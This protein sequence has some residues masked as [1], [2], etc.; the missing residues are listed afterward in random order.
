MINEIKRGRPIGSSNLVTTALR[1]K[2]N[3]ILEN[4]LNTI[5]SD[6]K[7]LEPK[8]RL[9]IIER[10]LNY[11]LPKLANSTNEIK[12]S[13]KIGLDLEDEIYI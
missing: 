10:F 6:L 7:S 1:N 13:P 11:S 5:E 9:M 4:S 12:V 8:D 2:V 3:M